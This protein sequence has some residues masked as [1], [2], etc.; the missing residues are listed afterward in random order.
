[1]SATALSAA[2]APLRDP[3]RH[4]HRI[5]MR[6]DQVFRAAASPTCACSCRCRSRRCRAS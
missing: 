5:A 3:L 6:I 4:R 1:V 2:P